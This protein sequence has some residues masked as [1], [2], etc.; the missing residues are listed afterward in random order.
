MQDAEK[1]DDAHCGF[2][3]SVGEG[4]AIPGT[5]PGAGDGRV[6]YSGG[7]GRG[8]RARRSTHC[9]REDERAADKDVVEMEAQLE[10]S[11]RPEGL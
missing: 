11:I 3:G 10:V 5:V 9:M 6:G 1:G 8:D 4:C 7:A 2:D